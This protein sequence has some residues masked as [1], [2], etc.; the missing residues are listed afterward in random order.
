MNEK[1]ATAHFLDELYG[2][3]ASRKGGNPES[4]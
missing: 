2:T 3:I 4:S 1:H